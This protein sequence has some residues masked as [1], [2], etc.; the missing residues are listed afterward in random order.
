MGVI[1]GESVYA[2]QYNAEADKFDQYLPP[3]QKI[4]ETF[5]I[6]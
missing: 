5:K 6:T 2:L 3:A 1:I 4:L